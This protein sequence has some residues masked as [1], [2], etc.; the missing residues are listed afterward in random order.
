MNGSGTPVPDP[1]LGT[2]L[3]RA[4]VQGWWGAE[5]VASARHRVYRVQSR[6]GALLA[7]LAPLAPRFATSIADE[8]R[9][10][11]RVAAV[12]IA[13][14]LLYFGEDG[15]LVTRWIDGPAWSPAELGCAAGAEALARKL[16]MLHSVELDMPVFDPVRAARAYSEA[17][18]AAVRDTP[19]IAVRLAALAR[20]LEDFVSDADCSRLAHNDLVPANVVGWPEPMLVD[21][22]YAAPFDRRFDL[23]CITALTPLAGRE[24]DRLLAANGLLPAARRE[25]ADVERLVRLLSWS[26]ALA[27]RARDPAAPHPREWLN[28][29]ERAL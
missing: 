27:E 6:E 5:R 26:W 28:R 18:P 1:A 23:A 13:P 4:N 9:V 25:L 12:G 16:E 20:E 3:A 17:L 22:E 29:L 21:W 11:A 2:L 7:R 8:G 10:L 14:E 15:G 24:R 19:A